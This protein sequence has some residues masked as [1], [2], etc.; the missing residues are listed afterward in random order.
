MILTWGD[1]QQLRWGDRGLTWGPVVL[2]PAVTY[3]RQPA[4]LLANQVA[5]QIAMEFWPIYWQGD[6]SGDGIVV[7]TSSGDRIETFGITD[8]PKSEYLRCLTRATNW[9]SADD[10]RVA[11]L[12]AMRKTGRVMFVADAQD[13]YDEKGGVYQRY[14]SIRVRS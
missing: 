11:F 9:K 14:F 12:A 4:M 2:V 5:T 10:L 3:P 1:Q 7:S 13:V 6:V 8:N